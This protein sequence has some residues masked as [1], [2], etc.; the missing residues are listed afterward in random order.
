MFILPASFATEEG[1]YA[2]STS[3]SFGFYLV[4]CIYLAAS[5]G[6]LGLASADPHRQPVLDYNYLAESSDRERLREGVRMTIDF[7]AHRPW[8][9]S[10]PSASAR[11]L[12]S[13][14]RTPPWMR[15]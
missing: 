1:Y 14:S 8:T 2:I 4:P 11:R 7:T 9:N 10:L 15:G 5:A 12:P 3:R 6:R 13:W